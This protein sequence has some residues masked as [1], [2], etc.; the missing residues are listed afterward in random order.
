[1]SEGLLFILWWA[2]YISGHNCFWW[3]R[4]KYW[5]DQYSQGYR[6]ATDLVALIIFFVL[7][8]GCIKP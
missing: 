1:M 3:I 4:A 7:W 8:F 5:N 2:V 6:S